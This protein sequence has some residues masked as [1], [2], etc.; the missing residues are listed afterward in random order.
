[1]ATPPKSPKR[2]YPP[3][4]RCIYCGDT[5]T[6]LSREH[7]IPLG[8]GGN[9]ILPEASCERCRTITGAFEQTAL[10][11]MFGPLRIRLGLPTR[12]P[13]ERPLEL[14]VSVIRQDESFDTIPIAASKI[15]R[16]LV[17]ARF[18]LPG[19]LTGRDP[20]PGFPNAQVISLS[21]HSDARKIMAVNQL[22]GIHLGQL[23]I[24]AFWKLLA[25]M[26]HGQAVAA[27]GI[28][29]FEPFL[30]E[31]IL[32]DYPTP[33][34]FIGGDTEIPERA[35][36]SLHQMQLREVETQGQQYLLVTI[37]LFALMGT[38]VHHVIA[39]RPKG[40]AEYGRGR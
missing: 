39:G 22:C 16:S 30:P 13:K 10:R 24:K 27:R 3:I 33:S 28:D 23:N 12:R 21:S 35:P 38:P 5:S 18:D 15:P 25:K 11:S 36:K 34:H 7:I 31:L 2:V 4:G 37:R 17:T 8:L 20:A 6:P 26:A 9:V 29:G 14:P 19:I 1:M 40:G 32:S